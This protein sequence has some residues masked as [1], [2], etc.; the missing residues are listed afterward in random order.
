M[1]ISQY[2]L[3]TKL[4][5]TVTKSSRI[6]DISSSKKSNLMGAV[7]GPIDK[8]N[9]SV[10]DVN[11]G[12]LVPR[13][14]CLKHNLFFIT[15]WCPKCRTAIWTTMNTFIPRIIPYRF[16]PSIYTFFWLRR[17]PLTHYF[18]NQWTLHWY[19]AVYI[20]QSY[21]TPHHRTLFTL[22]YFIFSPIM[23]NCTIHSSISEL[24]KFSVLNFLSWEV[25][26][27]CLIRCTDF[28]VEPKVMDSP[29]RK[30]V[31]NFRAKLVL[32]PEFFISNKIQSKCCPG[33]VDMEPVQ[34][35]G[36]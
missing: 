2:S 6:S 18:P 25:F 17:Y 31:K 12:S 19:S 26:F 16:F 29:S 3:V 22:P 35:H 14:Y 30:A 21:T 7:N 9:R 32:W 36:K 23:S 1:P 11:T 33:L 8:N 13:N 4:P 24:S 15:S 5:P 28:W 10:P 27:H 34:L 20:S